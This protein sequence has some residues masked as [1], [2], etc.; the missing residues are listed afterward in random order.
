MGGVQSLASSSQEDRLLRAV[1]SGSKAATCNVLAHAP[2]A[3]AN[4]SRSGALHL[5]AASGRRDVVKILLAAARVSL[6][7]QSNAADCRQLYAQ[8][9]DHKTEFGQT[10][11]ML[12]CK[13]GHA[14][15]AQLL[16]EEGADL[17][18]T[19]ES[20]PDAHQ[21][22]VDARA[23]GG[24]T[25]LHIAASLGCTEAVQ[26]LLEAGADVYLHTYAARKGTPSFMLLWRPMSCPLHMAAA[27]GDAAMVQSLLD[28]LAKR[29]AA[30]GE[31]ECDVRTML[32]SHNLRPC[33]VALMSGHPRVEQMLRPE[34]PLFPRGAA[35]LLDTRELRGVPTLVKATLCAGQPPPGR[36]LDVNPRYTGT[37]LKADLAAAPFIRLEKGDPAK[38]VLPIE[39][40]LIPVST[41]RAYSTGVLL[42]RCTEELQNSRANHSHTTFPD[43]CTHS[44]SSSSNGAL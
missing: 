29:Q 21:W 20:R 2:L 1:A 18:C 36:A 31:A 34:A 22:F 41:A 8:L 40:M 32:D 26:E 11:L 14:D 27:T 35:G 5:A 16:L 24:A 30:Q 25:A 39:W 33:D 15:V 42:N 28:V 4:F 17:Q 9:L 19:C 7:T 13:A 10:A 12:A 38:P 37:R 6:G 23:E 44:S 43:S 3:A